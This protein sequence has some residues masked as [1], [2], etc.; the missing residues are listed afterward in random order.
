MESNQALVATLSA[1]YRD[2]IAN[3]EGME[4]SEDEEDESEETTRLLFGGNG[5]KICQSRHRNAPS[6]EVGSEETTTGSPFRAKGNA[7]E[8]GGATD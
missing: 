3:D 2:I 5:I 8:T 7:S 4:E 1:E 6:Q